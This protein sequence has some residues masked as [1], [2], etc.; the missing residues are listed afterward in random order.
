MI[1]AVCPECAH[2]FVVQLFSCH[3]RNPLG[4]CKGFKAKAAHKA[5]VPAQCLDCAHKVPDAWACKSPMFSLEPG[6]ALCRD[7]WKAGCGGF[8]AKAAVLPDMAPED[9]QPMVAECKC[10]R[11]ALER[12]RKADAH[13]SCETIA[14]RALAEVDE[15]DK[16]KQ[17]GIDKDLF[18][19]DGDGRVHG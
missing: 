17:E 14:A 18:V 19:E 1:G 5:Y 10:F 11:R 7:V 13:Y 2:R 8:E 16:K 3:V 4:P 15:A 6:S 9:W 12:I